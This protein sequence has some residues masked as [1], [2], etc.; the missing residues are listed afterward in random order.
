MGPESYIVVGSGVFG[1]S[2]AL[3]LA[4]CKGG[5]HVMLVDMSLAPNPASASSD[6]NKIIRADYR[7]AMYAKLAV[8]A[9]NHWK[10]DPLYRSFFHQTGMLFAES[11]G[12]GPAALRNLENLGAA[13]GARLMTVDGARLA[14]PSLAEA[15]WSGV[16]GAYYN[17]GSGWAEADSALAA[18]VEEAVK[19]G[20]QLETA[21]VSRLL[22]DKCNPEFGPRWLCKGVITCDGTELF[23]DRILLCSGAA[24]AKILA[25]SAP[26]DPTL[27]ANGRLT[28]AAALQVAVR[29][30]PA[31]WATCRDTPVF[32][33]LMPHTS[34][35]M[36][37]SAR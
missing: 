6:V 5:A 31:K 29:V 17:P 11:E 7:D 34:G 20:V 18:V 21:E 24:T 16:R 10:S 15:N 8:E 3:E 27:H 13:E 2:A 25:N 28:A 26:K 12:K 23:A 4:R 9:I 32:A 36:T 14:F 1:A 35:E 30:P 33:N 22:L 19:Y 37:C